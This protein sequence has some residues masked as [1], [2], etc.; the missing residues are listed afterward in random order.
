[1]SE[2]GRTAP[3]FFLR[4]RFFPRASVRGAPLCAHVTRGPRLATSP[5][6]TTA[7]SSRSSSTPARP[8]I[9]ANHCFC[10][11]PAAAQ[12]KEPSLNSANTRSPRER[13]ASRDARSVVRPRPSV[14]FVRRRPHTTRR[15]SPSRSRNARRGP[16]MSGE[17]AIRY[18]DH[19]PPRP[20]AETRRRGNCTAPDSSNVLYVYLHGSA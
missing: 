14:L 9:V 16:A 13:S 8:R 7:R 11:K 10:P 3:L 5:S 6:R 17:S 4:A 15:A 1:M 19:S 20:A 12:E 18:Q 2:F